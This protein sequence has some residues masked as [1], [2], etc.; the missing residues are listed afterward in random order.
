VL[1]LNPL[2]GFVEA[3][4]GAMLPTRAIDWG[5]FGTS[6]AVTVLIFALSLWYFKKTEREFADV[7]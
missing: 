4:R 1:S 6:A 2:T 5:L 7:I 3:F